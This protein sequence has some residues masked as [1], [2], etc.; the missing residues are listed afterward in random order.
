MNWRKKS[1]LEDRYG[2]KDISSRTVK[3]SLSEANIQ[4]QNIIKSFGV[5]GFK[6]I[7]SVYTEDLEKRFNKNPRYLIL[8]NDHLWG[9]F[10]HYCVIDVYKLLSIQESTLKENIYILNF[11][12]DG[13]C[14]SERNVF[15]V[16]SFCEKNELWDKLICLEF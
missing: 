14:V 9:A 16:K 13:L 5:D 11:I 4:Y 12:N 6:D 3:K 8:H 7:T 1:K 10:I 2:T 15:E